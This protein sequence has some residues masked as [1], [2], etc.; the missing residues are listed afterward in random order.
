[1]SIL[2][3]WSILGAAV[4]GFLAGCALTAL[5]F[6]S[7][8]GKGYGNSAASSV[9]DIGSGIRVSI[10]RCPRCDSTYTDEDMGYC[11]RDGTLLT[12]V[13]SMPRSDDGE[14]TVVINRRN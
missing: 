6:L 5:F 2:Q 12:V 14:E 4:L 10:K 1:M 11:L 9:S 8:R 3:V 7:K 13:G